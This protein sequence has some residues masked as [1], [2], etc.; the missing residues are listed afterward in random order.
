[1]TRPTNALQD[2]RQPVV[3]CTEIHRKEPEREEEDAGRRSRRDPAPDRRWVPVL[4]LDGGAVLHARHGPGRNEPS[5]AAGPSEAGWRGIVLARRGRHPPVLHDT[6]NWPPH[7]RRAWGTGVSYP[8]AALRA[9]IAHQV[10]QAFLLRPA[11]L[12]QIDTALRQVL[13]VELLREHEG[14]GAD[15]RHRGTG[16]RHRAQPADPR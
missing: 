4:A 1:M 6:G 3:S 13:L 12:R 2:L 10:V 15:A 11:R 8:P 5:R 9:G 16:R 7:P 14:A